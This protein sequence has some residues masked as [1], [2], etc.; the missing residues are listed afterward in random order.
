M[1]KKWARSI[2]SA[3]TGLALSA[4]AAGAQD[5]SFCTQFSYTN[6]FASM[7]CGL[8]DTRTFTNVGGTGA[9]TL[10]FTGQTLAFITAPS[11][12]DLGTVQ[13]TGATGANQMLSGT[14]IFLRI[15]QFAPATP[16]M[17][18]VVGSMSGAIGG[19]SSTGIINWSTPSRFATI[20]GVTYEVERLSL[21]QTSINAQTTGP[22]TI[23][24]FVTATT[25]P[26]PSTV[27]LLGSGL[28]LLGGVAARRRRQPKV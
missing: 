12:A 16:G 28:A 5:L 2:T 21:G 8:G 20:N 1:N 15:L 11:F 19:T 24:A 23:R 22:Q 3:A 14:Q 9:A 27:I 7:S 4:T 13:V 10:T 26:E 17:A 6:S 25:V 18:T